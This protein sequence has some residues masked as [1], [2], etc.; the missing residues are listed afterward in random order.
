MTSPN[1]QQECIV[2]QE[3]NIYQTTRGTILAAWIQPQKNVHTIFLP[4]KPAKKVQLHYAL[5]TAAG[6]FGCSTILFKPG[7]FFLSLRT[8]TIAC[9]KPSSK[10]FTPFHADEHG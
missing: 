3:S 2:R 7:I 8:A 5:R 10:N 4:P 9:T 1:L 6:Q